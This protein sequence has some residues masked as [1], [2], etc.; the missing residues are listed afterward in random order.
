MLGS[1]DGMTIGMATSSALGGSF[2]GVLR[3]TM[4]SSRMNR[5]LKEMTK[6][7]ASV[8]TENIASSHKNSIQERLQ[9][10]K[11]AVD[12]LHQS[13]VSD[14]PSV[15]LNRDRYD[16]KKL[17]QYLEKALK[18]YKKYKETSIM[19]KKGT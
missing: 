18:K 7:I 12:L 13:N 8:L 14:E 5:Q 9:L 3:G 19:A 17:E 6:E 1:F 11:A 16:A 2:G 15:G 4:G 10:V